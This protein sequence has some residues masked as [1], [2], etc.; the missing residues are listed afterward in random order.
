[1]GSGAPA[2]PKKRALTLRNPDSLLLS[3][4][5][6]MFFPAA[7]FYFEKYEFCLMPKYDFCLTRECDACGQV[8][9][10]GFHYCPKCNIYLCFTCGLLLIQAGYDYPFSCLTCGSRFDMIRKRSCD[11][12]G[13]PAVDNL[14]VGCRIFAERHLTN[15]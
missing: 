3:P 5:C 8:C 15:P 6:R 1:M 11:I 13:M 7:Q 4:L 14:C 9:G 12:C 10:G 2:N